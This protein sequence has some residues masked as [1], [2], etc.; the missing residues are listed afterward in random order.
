MT[1]P[2]RELK[3]FERVA[4]APGETKTVRFK[5]GPNGR[6]VLKRDSVDCRSGIN[7]VAR[8]QWIDPCI[9]HEVSAQ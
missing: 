5:L 8:K 9:Q 3:G 1:R 4:L 7:R 2:V 6:L